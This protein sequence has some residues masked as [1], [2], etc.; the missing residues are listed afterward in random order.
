MARDLS[1]LLINAVF[2]VSGN[3]LSLADTESLHIGDTSQNIFHCYK[4]NSNN[5]Q[6]LTYVC[7]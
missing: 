2:V 7:V 6:K 4:Q 3:V 1:V 5:I